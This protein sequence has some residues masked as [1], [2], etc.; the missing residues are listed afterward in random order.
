MLS[1][2]PEGGREGAAPVLKNMRKKARTSVQSPSRLSLVLF[3]PL[4]NWYESSEDVK[5]LIYL[6]DF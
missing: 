4:Q 6:K 3:F 1:Q 2:A 5:F